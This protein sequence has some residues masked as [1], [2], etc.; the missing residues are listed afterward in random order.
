[1]T[2]TI[3]PSSS[4][5]SSSGVE[6]RADPLEL[7]LKGLAPQGVFVLLELAVEVAPPGGAAVCLRRRVPQRRED[8]VPQLGIG[9]EAVQPVDDLFLQR[10]G[11]GRRL[12][13]AVAVAA[14]RA[15][16]A[17][18]FFQPEWKSEYSATRPRPFSSA[19]RW[20]AS[21]WAS[22]EKPCPCSSVDSR[23]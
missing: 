15:E 5:R 19:K 23:T 18:A 20:I 14:G 11:M 2:A 22:G 3:F 7:L 13:A 12:I 6:R 21:R 4:A 17:T 1:L 16:V 9:L 10:L 8:D